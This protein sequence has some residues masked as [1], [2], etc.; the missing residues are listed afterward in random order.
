M[1]TM[2][3]LAHLASDL[4]D[5]VSAEIVE[6]KRTVISEFLEC[7]EEG[8]A[9]DYILDWAIECNRPINDQL[10]DSLVDYFTPLQGWLN[11]AT[12]KRLEVVPHAA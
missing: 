11:E 9:V 7:G 2:S 10:R 12:R 6:P 8:C 1:K 3:V 5:T 4:F